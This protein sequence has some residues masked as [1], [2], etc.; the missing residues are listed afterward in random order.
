MH[1]EAYVVLICF[2]KVSIKLKTVQAAQKKKSMEISWWEW[3]RWKHFNYFISDNYTDEVTAGSAVTNCPP[4]IYGETWEMNTNR[5]GAASRLCLCRL[6]RITA[7]LSF[8]FINMECYVK[9][10][11][12]HAKNEVAGFDGTANLDAWE[13]P[14]DI[15][16]STP[17]SV[18]QVLQDSQRTG[19]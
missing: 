13:Q 1:A 5:R 18:F 9:C 17:G 8:I 15:Q 3:W 14:D 7:A 2:N 4:E 12:L 6:V 11:N 19:Q 16:M 10:L